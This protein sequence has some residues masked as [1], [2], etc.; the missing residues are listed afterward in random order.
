[1]IKSGSAVHLDNLDGEHAERGVLVITGTKTTVNPSDGQAM[2]FIHDK[3]RDEQFMK[4]LV[5]KMK[6]P[7]LSVKGLIEAANN[8]LGATLNN[9]ASGLP[10]FTINVDSELT[11]QEI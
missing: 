10:K 1:M 2:F 3:T 4:T 6:I 9:L 8:Q 11:V 7:G 5:E